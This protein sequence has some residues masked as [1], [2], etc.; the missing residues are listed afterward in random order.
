M[1][2][3]VDPSAQRVQEVLRQ[4]RESA[5][6]LCYADTKYFSNVNEAKSGLANKMP[7]LLILGVPPQF[8]GTSMANRNLETQVIEAFGSS[9]AIFC[10]KP[11][12]TARPEASGKIAEMIEKCGS[13]ISIGYM[14]RYLKVVQK[15]KKIMEENNIKPLSISARYTSAYTKITK[16]DWWTKSKQCGPIVEQGTHLCDLMRYFGGEV[17]LNTVQAM[18]LEHYEDA[19]KLQKLDVDEDAIPA[20]DRIPRATAAVWSVDAFW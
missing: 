12:S 7:H 5:A 14:F 1:V 19:G 3:I 20:D 16:P 15:A 6:A 17:D 10:E 2:G 13:T 4:K 9:P 11:V 8:R 18:A